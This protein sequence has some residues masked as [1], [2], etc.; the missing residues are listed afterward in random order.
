MS[1]V[2]LV[3]EADSASDLQKQVAEYVSSTQ[4]VTGAAPAAPAA[5]EAETVTSE[6][7]KPAKTAKP[8]KET[9]PAAAPEAEEASEEGEGDDPFGTAEESEPEGEAV[10]FDQANSALEEVGKQ[11]G[12][13]AVR[14]I[15]AKFKIKKVKDIKEDQYADVVKACKKTLG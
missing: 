4:A 2:S 9:K 13:P 11:K 10:T 6:P 7:A 15:L 1:K 12:I 8:K 5:K 3:F 14:E